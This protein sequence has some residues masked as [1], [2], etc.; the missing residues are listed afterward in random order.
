MGRREGY[1]D[2]STSLLGAH[3][4]TSLAT[5]IIQS[6]RSMTTIRHGNSGNKINW[7]GFCAIRKYK[8]FYP[9]TCSG[10]IDCCE[11]GKMHWEIFIEGLAGV[12]TYTVTSVSMHGNFY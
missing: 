10:I 12:T 2:V 7:R 11:G 8:F 1:G 9:Y 5:G 6:A 4:P 3:I